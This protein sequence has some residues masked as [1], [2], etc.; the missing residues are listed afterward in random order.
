MIEYTRLREDNFLRKNIKFDHSN[1]K[2]TAYDTTRCQR[3]QRFQLIIKITALKIHI[4]LF[5]K[6]RNQAILHL[7]E[8]KMY[9]NNHLNLLFYNNHYA[10]SGFVSSTVLVNRITFLIILHTVL[11]AKMNTSNVF[12][13]VRVWLGKANLVKCMIFHFFL[14]FFEIFVQKPFD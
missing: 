11:A 2:Y 8:L 6:I 4:K 10:P 9:W 12:S 3:L 1:R 5:W 14:L 13:Y 7:Q